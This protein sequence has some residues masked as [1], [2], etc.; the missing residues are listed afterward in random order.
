MDATQAAPLCAVERRA[1]ELIARTIIDARG[2][3]EALLGVVPQE[4]HAAVFAFLNK[5][6]E[7]VPIARQVLAAEGAPRRPMT[8][9]ESGTLGGRAALAK[10][11]P[12]HYKAV[13]KKGGDASFAKLGREHFREIARK[14]G[15]ARAAQSRALTGADP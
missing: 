15:L 2:A 1:L 9:S 6:D 13:G 8:M 5:L 3:A 10:H 4:K 11:G 7:V 12:E 14:G